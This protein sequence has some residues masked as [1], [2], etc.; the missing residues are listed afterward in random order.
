MQSLPLCQPTHNAIVG[1]TVTFDHSGC[2]GVIRSLS[3]DHSFT[4]TSCT[5]FQWK[6]IFVTVVR[7]AI[8]PQMLKTQLKGYAINHIFTII[9]MSTFLINTS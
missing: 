9:A 3:V 8:C 7:G 4:D 1:L 2:T 6:A 5:I